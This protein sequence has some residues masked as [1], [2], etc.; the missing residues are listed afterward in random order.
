MAESID[1]DEGEA[2]EV[3]FTS[4]LDIEAH[5]VCGYLE[6]HGVPCHIRNRRFGLEPLTFGALGQVEVLVPNPW[7]RVA[8]GM[9]RGRLSDATPR[10]R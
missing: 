7:V 9:I 10:A 6:Q 2:W 4:A 5:I 1:G 8:R 3:C